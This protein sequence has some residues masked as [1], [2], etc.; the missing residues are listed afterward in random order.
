HIRLNLRDAQEI[1]NM[2]GLINEI[3]AIEQLDITAGDDASAVLG[4]RLDSLLPEGKIIRIKAIAQASAKQRTMIEHYSSFI[5][6][7]VVSVCVAWIGLLAMINVRERKQEIGLMRAVGYGSGKI[8]LLFLGKAV[9]IGLFGVAFGFFFGT[10]LALAFGSDVFK[11]TV[12]AITPS[13]KLLGML[14]IA[15][16]LLSVASSLIPAMIAAKQDP[17]VTLAQL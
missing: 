3:Q 12:E 5:I 14:L 10:V 4:D 13:Y 15:A 9:I 8:V 2:K 1:L 17:A 6:F 11:L 7:T 16:P